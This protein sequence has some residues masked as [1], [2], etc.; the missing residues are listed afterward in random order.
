LDGWGTPL[1]YEPLPDA[2]RQFGPNTYVSDI[3]IHFLLRSAGPDRKY[4]TDDDCF[5]RNGPKNL[6]APLLPTFR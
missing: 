5:Y 6:P 2:P 3:D 4:G 1:R